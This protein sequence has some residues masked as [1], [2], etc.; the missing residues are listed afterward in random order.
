[1]SWLQQGYYS[2]KSVV[3][4]WKPYSSKSADILPENDFGRSWS[5]RLEY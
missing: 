1:M 3:Y 2:L 4:T 5:H